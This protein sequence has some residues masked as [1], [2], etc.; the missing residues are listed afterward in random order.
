MNRFNQPKHLRCT[1]TMVWPSL[2]LFSLGKPGG[3]GGGGS[4]IGYNGSGVSCQG[5]QGGGG[6]ITPSGGKYYEWIEHVDVIRN[7]NHVSL[8]TSF[9]VLL[10]EV[11]HFFNITIHSRS[12]ERE[13]CISLEKSFDSR[14][15]FQ[16]LLN[17]FITDVILFCRRCW[18]L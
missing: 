5:Y 12:H 11:S 6:Q 17:S 10:E 9:Q 15:M 16:L 1:C 3:S 8:S 18:W 7:S 2:T 13:A 14:C 4:C